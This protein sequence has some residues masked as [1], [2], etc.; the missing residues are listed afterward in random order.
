[1]SGLCPFCYAAPRPDEF[2]DIDDGEVVWDCGTSYFV[3][4]PKRFYRVEGCRIG[5][6]AIARFRESQGQLA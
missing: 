2:P 5:E 1:M 4:E 6:A 3:D